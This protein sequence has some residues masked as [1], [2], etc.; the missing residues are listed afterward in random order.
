MKWTRRRWILLGFLVPAVG[1]LVANIGWPGE[2]FEYLGIIY[3]TPVIM[4]NAT[5]WLDPEFMEKLGK[6]FGKRGKVTE[7]EDP[8][9]FSE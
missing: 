7:Q 4:L 6:I 2:T 1:L 9:N 3:A 8:N 5:E